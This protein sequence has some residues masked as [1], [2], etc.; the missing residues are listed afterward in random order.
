MFFLLLKCVDSGMDLWCLQGYAVEK[1]VYI[2]ISVVGTKRTNF[3]TI[4]DP[5]K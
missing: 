2:Y 5:C 4:V 3:N 1:E